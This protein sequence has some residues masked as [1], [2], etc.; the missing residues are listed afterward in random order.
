MRFAPEAFLPTAAVA[1]P[2]TAA[3]LVGW[4]VVG[5]MLLVVAA[6]VLL[7]FR[8]PERRIPEG[9]GLVV[10]PADG[11]VVEIAP[12]A[13]EEKG[14]GGP[15]VRVS[16]FLSLFNVH[17]NRAPVAGK[18]TGIR[19]RPGQFLAAYRSLASIRNEQNRLDLACGSRRLTVVQIA[20]VIARRIVCR[21]RVGDHLRRGERIGL[22][23][24]GSRVDLFLPATVELRVQVGDRV[25]GGSSIL[26]RLADCADG[27]EG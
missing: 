19:Y 24:F 25:Q 17:I 6:A 11:R 22:I 16:I 20:G 7:F 8:D 23:Q 1:L 12:S 15:R 9:E 3:C 13:E 5:G 18:V 2:G 4:P 27:N 14:E 26:G 10:S 21:A